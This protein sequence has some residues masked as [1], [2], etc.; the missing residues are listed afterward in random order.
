M[1]LVSNSGWPMMLTIIG[2]YT[3]ATL[4]ISLIR[5]KA[6]VQ[7]HWGFYRSKDDHSTIAPTLSILQIYCIVDSHI[8]CL[9][10]LYLFRLVS[11]KLLF[12]ILCIIFTY[13]MY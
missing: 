9:V 8:P 5:D 6:M 1:L 7:V 11:R 2:G 10:I 12:V 4:T 13:Q 3:D